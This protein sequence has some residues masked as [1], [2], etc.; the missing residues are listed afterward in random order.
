MRPARVGA[1]PSSL[2][3]IFAGQDFSLALSIDGKVFGWGNRKAWKILF[4]NTLIFI[5]Y[6]NMFKLYTYS[7]R[8]FF[9][10]T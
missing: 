9:K 10:P 7:I 4:L 6:I 8:K 2:S 3:G 5:H 1:L